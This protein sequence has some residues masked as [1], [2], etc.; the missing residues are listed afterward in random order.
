MIEQL[1]TLLCKCWPADWES[2]RTSSSLGGLWDI[3]YI[4]YLQCCGFSVSKIQLVWEYFN[5]IYTF[6]LKH[7]R[8]CLILALL[9][10]Q[11][12]REKFFMLL[13]SAVP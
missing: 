13:Q 3:L 12:K 11:T 7:P 1:C 9:T 5:N 2:E 6:H 10:M 8:G 4:I